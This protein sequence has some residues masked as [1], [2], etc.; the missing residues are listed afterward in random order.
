MELLF[1]KQNIVQPN[2]MTDHAAMITVF[3]ACQR[4]INENLEGDFVETGV[5][6][7]GLSAIFLRKIIRQA[8]GKKLWLYDTFEGMPEPTAVDKKMTFVGKITAAEKFKLVSD[9]EFSNWCRASLDVVRN[10]LSCVTPDY[11]DHTIFV[12]GK[13]EDTLIDSKNIPDKISVLRLDTDWYI[14]TKA[15]MEILY[16]RVVENGYVIIDDY[17][18]W[19]GCKKAVD[20]YLIS[21]PKASYSKRRY[22]HRD[23]KAL[24]IKK[25]AI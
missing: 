20:E 21:L 4:V 15:E 3:R 10:T 17:F 25:L 13:V 7:G 6:K 22:D 12:K 9:G 19:S 11:A 14:S 8:K 23:K 5:W 16:P 24:I 18:H 2:T 1:F